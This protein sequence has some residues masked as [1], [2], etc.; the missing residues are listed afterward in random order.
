MKCASMATKE[1]AWLIICLEKLEKF[2]LIYPSY[3]LI[4]RISCKNRQC[5]GAELT[6][7]EM[8]A[9]SPYC[10]SVLRP[11][12][13]PKFRDFSYFNMTYIKNCF[14][15]SNFQCLERGGQP[16]RHLHITYTFNPTPLQLGLILLSAFNA[17]F[18]KRV[19]TRITWGRL[20]SD[21][22][23]CVI[24]ASKFDVIYLFNTRLQVNIGHR[25]ILQDILFYHNCQV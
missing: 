13:T 19:T 11:S 20:K 16:P 17:Y 3:A 18:Q 14:F 7:F 9:K 24:S 4:K 1:I 5:N 22:S 15:H 23:T 10:N 21:G 2:R 8:V 25:Y 6:L 12:N